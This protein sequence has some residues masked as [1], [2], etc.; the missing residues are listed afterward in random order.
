MRASR[1]VVLLALFA[2]LVPS[3]AGADWLVTPFIGLKF[4]GETSFADLEEGAGVTKLTWGGS[5]GFLSDG[6]LGVEMDFGHSPGFFENERHMPLVAHSNVT[7][8][9]GNVLVALPL[10]VTRESLRPYAL[11]GLGLMHASIEYLANPFGVDANLLGLTIGGGVIGF[12]TDRTGLRFELRHFRNITNEDKSSASL[13]STHLSF[14][15]AT[16]GVTFRY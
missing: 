8:L 2:C 3:R 4:A 16:A 12:V 13:G 6:I 9:T 11:G 10:S 14:W 15:R 1:F 5:V 7:T